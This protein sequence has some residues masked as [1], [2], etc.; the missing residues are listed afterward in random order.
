MV[1][2]ILGNV[3]KRHSEVHFTVL[4]KHKPGSHGYI[5]KRGGTNE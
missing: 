5:V 1:P 3:S 4:A 2:F